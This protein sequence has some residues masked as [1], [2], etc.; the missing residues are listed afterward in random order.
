MGVPVLW[1]GDIRVTGARCPYCGEALVV[2][3][4]VNPVVCRKCGKEF[5]Q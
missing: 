4:R 1:Y 3:Y 2:E 5:S